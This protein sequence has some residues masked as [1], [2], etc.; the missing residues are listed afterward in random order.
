[1]KTRVGWV[2]RTTLFFIN[3]G[4][5]YFGPELC[6]IVQLKLCDVD[7]VEI[8]QNLGGNVKIFIFEPCSCICSVKFLN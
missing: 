8:V 6:H 2:I 7:I 3:F 4:H 1:V 5:K